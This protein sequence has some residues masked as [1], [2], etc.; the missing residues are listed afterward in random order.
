[1]LNKRAASY[2]TK[3]MQAPFDPLRRHLGSEY[4]SASRR[5]RRCGKFIV[6]SLGEKV[7]ERWDNRRR[8]HYE[9]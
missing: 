3:V 5:G 1:M 7:E 4:W 2:S 9:R 8:P 6:P